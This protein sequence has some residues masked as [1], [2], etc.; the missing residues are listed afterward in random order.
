MKTDML[1]SSQHQK[2]RGF[3][4]RSQWFRN[5]KKILLIMLALLLT[6]ALVT[7]CSLKNR[8]KDGESNETLTEMKGT[9]D[10]STGDRMHGGERSE[11]NDGERPGMPDG[12]RPEMPDGERPEMPDGERPEMPDG[13]RPEMPDGE[14]P[15]MPDGERADGGRAEMQSGRHGGSGDEAQHGE[16]SAPQPG[17]SAPAPSEDAADE[18]PGAE[19][20]S[21]AAPD[22]GENQGAE[23]AI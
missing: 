2:E 3:A 4:T 5:M 11:T 13:E 8:T 15:E 12:E 20:S 17:S 16:G 18:G 6:A 21:P 9:L 19:D 14:R 23:P 22:G 1:S 7:G 10:R